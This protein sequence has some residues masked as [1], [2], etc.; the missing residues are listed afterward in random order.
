[1]S[2]RYVREKFVPC[3][4]CAKPAGLPFCRECLER[5]ELLE[6]VERLRRSHG[7][8]T[9]IRDLVKLCSHCKGSPNSECPEHGR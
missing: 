3:S 2:L 4:T 9:Y 8:R 1:M 7:L 5:R 6:V